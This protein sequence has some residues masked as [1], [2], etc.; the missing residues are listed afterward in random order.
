MPLASG[1]WLS[2]I[3]PLAS[4][5]SCIMP[6]ASG[7]GLSCIIPLAAGLGVAAGGVAAAGVVQAATPRTLTMERDTS[8]EARRWFVRFMSVSRSGLGRLTIAAI[9]DGGMTV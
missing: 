4:G 5:L 7:L 9:D 8:N 2:C 1:L 3:M 6:L